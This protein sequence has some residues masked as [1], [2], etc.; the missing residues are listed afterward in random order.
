[1]TEAHTHEHVEH[2]APAKKR[3]T[4]K[5][6]IHHMTHRQMEIAAMER[7]LQAAFAPYRE[8]T[9]IL[10]NMNLQQIFA[11]QK[12]IEKYKAQVQK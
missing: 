7:R 10:A 3:V 1:M 8:K 12:K 9:K 5:K 6:V 11:L 2:T 4:R